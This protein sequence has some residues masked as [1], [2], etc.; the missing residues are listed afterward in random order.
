MQQ[1]NFLNK[2]QLF[3]VLKLF[4]DCQ[5]DEDLINIVDIW[6]LNIKMLEK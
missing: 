2:N 4:N 5:N 3:I 6:I 1:K